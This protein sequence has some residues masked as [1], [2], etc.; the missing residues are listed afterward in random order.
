MLLVLFIANNELMLARGLQMSLVG[1]GEEQWMFGQML[2]LVS[3]VVHGVELVRVLCIWKVE[4]G[5]G[6]RESRGGRGVRFNWSFVMDLDLVF[7]FFQLYLCIKLS[8]YACT[9]FKYLKE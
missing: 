9:L 1:P 5:G 8:L 2:A 6:G 4:R 7:F 3:L